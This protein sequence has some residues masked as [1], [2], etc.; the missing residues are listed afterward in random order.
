MITGGHPSYAPKD[1]TSI[2]TFPAN[3]PCT[4][5]P[6]PSPGKFPLFKFQYLL[7]KGGLSTQFP[8]STTCWWLAVEGD[9]MHLNL[10]YL[11]A[12]GSQTGHI[13]TP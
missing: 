9:H 3:A 2:E 12:M 4:I 10:V 6:F 1:P 5:P 7:L 11:G 8:L 13:T